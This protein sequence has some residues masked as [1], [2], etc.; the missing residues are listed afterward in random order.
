MLPNTDQIQANSL[1]TDLSATGLWV[2]CGNSCHEDLRWKS[3]FPWSVHFPWWQPLLWIQEQSYVSYFGSEVI[4]EI[5]TWRWVW[6]LSTY[7]VWLPTIIVIISIRLCGLHW[8][9]SFPRSMFHIGPAYF[10]CP[11]ILEGI[12]S[13]CGWSKSLKEKL[14]DNI[15]MTE[16]KELHRSATSCD[17]VLQWHWRSSY[18]AIF[19]PTQGKHWTQN[20]RDFNNTHPERDNKK[21]W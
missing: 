7:S 3:N 11:L 4:G 1:I 8:I 18:S 14:S 21:C 13:L 15:T 6:S 20:N 9:T 12:S 5:Y 16:S 19:K 2:C 10:L 17:C